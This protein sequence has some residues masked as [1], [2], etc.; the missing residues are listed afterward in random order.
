MRAHE[1]LAGALTEDWLRR[2]TTAAGR[3]P[4]RR[5]FLRPFPSLP[6]R[7]R[8]TWKPTLPLAGGSGPNRP[9]S[10]LRDPTL[11]CAKD[12][13]VRSAGPFYATVAPLY[14]PLPRSEWVSWRRASSWQEL[15][16]EL[17]QVT[18]AEEEVA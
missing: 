8:V 5:E 11:P 7:E 14:D 6:K 3:A 1:V 15:P 17:G 2:N 16:A 12:T 10:V 18:K 9:H 4:R 13:S